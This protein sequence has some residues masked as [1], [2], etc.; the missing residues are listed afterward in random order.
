[1]SVPTDNNIS[2][3]EYNRISRYKDLKV[4]IEKIWHLKTATIPVVVGA[5]GMI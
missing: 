2:I 5:L 1:M 3:K 4:E